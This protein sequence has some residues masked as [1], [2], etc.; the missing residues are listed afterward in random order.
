MKT[1]IARIKIKNE[2]GEELELSIEEARKLFEQL[3]EMFK[4]STP[5]IAPIPAPDQSPIEP[6]IPPWQPWPPIPWN[7]PTYPTTPWSPTTPNYPIIYC[8]AKENIC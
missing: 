1:S 7:P 3:K 4:E 2:D 8:L 6:F 5:T